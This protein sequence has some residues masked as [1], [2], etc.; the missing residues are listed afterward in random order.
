M[1]HINCG[2]NFEISFMYYLNAYRASRAR[3]L[4]KLFPINSETVD[5]MTINLGQALLLIDYSEIYFFARTVS[6]L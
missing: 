4:Q 6:K 3:C 1:I 2:I 5:F